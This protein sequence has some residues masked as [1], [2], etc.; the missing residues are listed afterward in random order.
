M[1][2]LPEINA[3]LRVLNAGPAKQDGNDMLIDAD[4]SGGSDAATD[5]VQGALI[6]P[7]NRKL[8]KNCFAVAGADAAELRIS[9]DGGCTPALNKLESAPP[10]ALIDAPQQR[11]QDVVKDPKSLNRLKI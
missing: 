3:S 1:A 9:F 6:A 5:L 8:G 2:V 11:I 4:L 10:E 7:L